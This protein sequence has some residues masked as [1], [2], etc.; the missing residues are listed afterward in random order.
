METFM[1]FTNAGKKKAFSG[2]AFC[3]TIIDFKVKKKK[4][5]K[6]KKP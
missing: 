5:K 4:K 6:K 2:N 3:K 1:Q